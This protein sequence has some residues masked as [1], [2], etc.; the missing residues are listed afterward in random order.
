MD[1]IGII[2]ENSLNTFYSGQSV[3]GF[4]SVT[5][6]NATPVRGKKIKH[7]NFVAVALSFFL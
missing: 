5:L 6:L 1:D 2:F 4:V 3:S 7:A